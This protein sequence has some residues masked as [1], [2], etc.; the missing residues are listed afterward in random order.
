[1]V[2]F[3]YPIE[4]LPR[5]HLWDHGF[6]LPDGVTRVTKQMLMDLVGTGNKYFKLDEHHFQCVGSERQ[7]VRPAAQV[8][9]K[10]TAQALREADEETYGQYAEFL[11]LW[12]DF[13]DVAN[14][15]REVDPN[16]PLKSGYGGQH[17]AEQK[18][19]LDRTLEYAQKLRGITKAGR[20]KKGLIP[21]Q[22]GIMMV[23]R[24]IPMIWKEL[25]ERY[26]ADVAFM[27]TARLNQD[28]IE[29][30]FSCIR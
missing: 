21:F 13:F 16:K 17:V 11:E 27:L 4:L 30:L 20:T 5:N 9:S 26:P 25:Q 19:I 10:S 18:K 14:S 28:I 15:T 1:M 6:M 2:S 3:L 8:F 12:N 29:N 22:K 23:C 24:A 7:R